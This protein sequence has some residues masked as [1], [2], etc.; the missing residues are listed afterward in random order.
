MNVNGYIG[1]ITLQ[2]WHPVLLDTFIE[3]ARSLVDIE[4]DFIETERLL[5]EN[6]EKN[7]QLAN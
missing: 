5:L 2:S 7:D 1:D 3:R 4:I 6:V